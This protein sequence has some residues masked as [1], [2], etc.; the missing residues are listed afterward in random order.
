MTFFVRKVL[1]QA[2][3]G[4]LTR[5]FLYQAHLFFTFA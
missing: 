1:Q 5:S 3:A 2:A 4:A